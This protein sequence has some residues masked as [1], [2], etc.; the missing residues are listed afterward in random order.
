MLRTLIHGHAKGV[1]AELTALLSQPAFQ[2]HHDDADR[3]A[4]HR[5]TYAQLAAINAWAG[6]GSALL[7]DRDRFFSMLS[8]AATINPALFSA[9]QSHYGV[10]LS[11]VMML[12]RP[13]PALDTLIGELDRLDSAATILITEVGVACSHMSVETHADYDP[14]ADEFVL[15]TPHA[16]ACKFMGN[17]ALDGVA[18]TAI[19]YARLRAGGRQHGL[20]PFVVPVRDRERVHDGIHI[21]ALPGPTSL[22]LDYSIAS[23]DRVRVPRAH[24]LQDSATLDRD[25]NVSDPLAGSDQRLVRSL[26]ISTNASTATS[27]AAAAAARACVWTALRY[28][29]HRK[30]SAR[31][32]TG[33]TLL[34]LRNQQGLLFTALAEAYVVSGFAR[35]LVEQQGTQRK[36]NDIATVPWAA[37]NRLAALTKAVAVSGAAE[38]MRRCRNASGSHGCLGVNRYHAYEDLTDAYTWAGGDNQLILIEIGRQLAS[39]PCELPDEPSPPGA[40]DSADAI[41]RLARFEE[42][43]QHARATAGLTPAQLGD[44]DFSATWEPRL[45]ALLDLA[46]THGA[47]LALEAMLDHPADGADRDALLALA[48]IHALEHFGGA[49]DYVTRDRIAFTAYDAV[50]AQL[51]RLLDAFELNTEMVA[52]PIAQD[53]YVRAYVG[54]LP[55]GG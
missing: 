11:S 12:G 31:L 24:W 6:S 47:R 10:C 27:V 40:L 53:D 7:V 49:L 20:F 15:T 16:G 39:A 46:R 44:A 41:R 29:S 32:G 28:A 26:A 45:P 21:R 5:R 43:R 30:T 50:L 3:V 22:D 18:K 4:Q 52:A 38:V 54:D 8:F 51:D 1:H 23:F 55:V 25:G 14:Q 34:A 48:A 17:I 37:V 36:M 35:R 2:P 42:R 19:V 13:S 9:A 33:R